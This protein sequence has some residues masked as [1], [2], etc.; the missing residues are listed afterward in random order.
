MAVIESGS[1]T[2]GRANV[3]SDNNL[4]VNMPGH[5][6]AGQVRGGGPANAGDVVLLCESD[7][8]SATGSR[9]VV[10]PE[11]DHDYRM[12]AMESSV[13]HEVLTYAAQNTGKHAYANTTMTVTWTA[14]GMTTNGA[15]ITT[16]TTGARVR[17]WAEFPLFTVGMTYL[18]VQFALTA[19]MPTNTAIDVGFFRDGGANPFAP[20]DGAWFRLTSSGYTGVISSGGAETS[21]ALGSLTLGINEFHKLTISCSSKRVEFWVDDVLRGSIEQPAA[22]GQPWLSTSQPFAIRHAIVGGAASAVVQA[23][24]LAYQV[25]LGGF[26]VVSGA[27]ESGARC[28]GSHQGL[29]GGTMGSLASYANSTTPAGGAGSNSTPL[30]TGLG[31]QAHLNAPAT[32]AT[33]LILTSYQVPAGTTAVQ[34]RRLVLRGV[35]IAATNLG[36]AVATTETAL[37]Y[38]LAFGHTSATMASAEGAAGKAPRREALG[39]LSWA[40]GA[41]IGSP[42]REGSINVPLACPIYV[43]PGEHI[44]VVCKALVG[45]ATAAQTIY[46]HILFDYGWE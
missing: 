45:T 25:T 39:M 34:G 13:D 44:A 16:T 33:D 8:G 5:T 12:R 23:K 38:S 35:R 27:G 46:H 3:D 20:T 7:P 22:T 43:N 32:A 31:G 11:A 15:S 1:S 4:H 14:S 6:A 17:T 10:P 2:S 30:V 9:L 29:G 40:V 18:D 37:A 41:A 36:A 28:W 42:A 24:V 19:A 21:V 26:G